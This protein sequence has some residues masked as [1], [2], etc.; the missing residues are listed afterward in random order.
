MVSRQGQGVRRQGVLRIVAMRIVT[1]CSA[2]LCIIVPDMDFS[3]LA[4][5]PLN[6]PFSIGE[7]GLVI[8]HIIYVHNNRIGGQLKTFIE[9]C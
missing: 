1:E 9:I 3:T 5:S 4:P 7:G 6:P 2:R 8:A